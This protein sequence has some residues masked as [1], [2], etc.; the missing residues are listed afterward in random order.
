V[1]TIR[2]RRGLDIEGASSYPR[3]GC[4]APSSPPRLGWNHCHQRATLIRGQTGVGKSTLARALAADLGGDVP[5]ILQIPAASLSSL[6]LHELAEL[7]RLCRPTVLIV[8]D[9][10]FD[11]EEQAFLLALFER[12]REAG[13]VV[14]LTHMVE[15]SAVSPSPAPGSLYIPGMRPGRIDEIIT[16]FPPDSTERRA[17]LAA[18]MAEDPPDHVVTRSAGL[19]AAYL[20][21][22]GVRLKGG[23]DPDIEIPSILATA[24][25][26]RWGS[27][28]EIEDDEGELSALAVA[29]E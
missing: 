7:V 21:E 16:L 9:I 28:E 13:T 12:V 17:I 24:P 19:T 18:A 6:D 14:L 29:N 22:L 5:R 27:D 8:D 2:A 23:C 25:L 15:P 1:T 4:T 10:A 3:A 20:L 11:H 26:S